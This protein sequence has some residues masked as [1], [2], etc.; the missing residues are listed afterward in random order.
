ME[1]DGAG[2][3][4]RTGQDR[5][6]P[7]H[8]SPC[9]TCAQVMTANSWV[10]PGGG[11]W[12]NWSQGPW[13]PTGGRTG[14]G[15]PWTPCVI[16]T[17]NQGH[18]PLNQTAQDPPEVTFVPLWE[19]HCCQWKSRHCVTGSRWG[20]KPGPCP[21]MLWGHHTSRF[22]PWPRKSCPNWTKEATQVKKTAVMI[23]AVGTCGA[24]MMAPRSVPPSHG[25]DCEGWS[26]GSSR[27]GQ[28]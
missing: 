5:V 2:P 7:G 13:C 26:Q 9:L 28:S 15:L 12:Q 19:T 14:A 23:S 22:N 8:V 3:S 27:G 18:I 4:A 17:V 25:G 11:R 24:L 10:G 16:C 21:E 6:C 20:V 1:Q